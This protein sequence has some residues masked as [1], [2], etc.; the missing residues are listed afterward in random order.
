LLAKTVYYN[1]NYIII[2]LTGGYGLE[3]YDNV[4]PKIIGNRQR[5]KKSGSFIARNINSV[6]R[7]VVLDIPF[8]IY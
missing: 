5:L 1:E 4:L 6:V 3:I 7:I 8:D 2:F